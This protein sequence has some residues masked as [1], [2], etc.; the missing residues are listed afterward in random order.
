MNKKGICAFALS[1]AALVPNA[2]AANN[3]WFVEGAAFTSVYNY[4]ESD[5]RKEL[6]E[7][8]TQ[9]LGDHELTGS[10]NDLV[11]YQ[12]SL[13]YYLTSDTSLKLTYASGI[14]LGFLDGLDCL[15][16]SQDSERYDTNADLTIFTA[17]VT[18]RFY[19]IS[20]SFHV[21][22]KAGVAYYSIDSTTRQRQSSEWTPIGSE[23]TN[24]WGVVGGL[25]IAWDIT[26][27]LSL[28]TSASLHQ[29]MAMKQYSMTVEYRF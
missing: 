13:G 7:S 16:C 28:N 25:G 8:V 14:E 9:Y 1:V 4:N 18:H 10:D 19:Q 11:N 23:T 24:K 21:Y 6:P 27:N 3:N 22:G 17:E 2:H 12:L 15:F 20:K 5:A 26:E 29:F